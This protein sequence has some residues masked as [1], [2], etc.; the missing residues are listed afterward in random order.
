MK[1][2]T[3][4][5]QHLLDPKRNPYREHHVLVEKSDYDNLRN[6]Y[7]LCCRECGGYV[8]WASEAEYLWLTHYKP[9]A[10]FRQLFWAP[11]YNE[12]FQK[13]VIKLNKEKILANETL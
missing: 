9:Q 8:K 12:E 6:R 4:H 13:I 2:I 7:K 1:K 3:P 11:A 10:T 5:Q